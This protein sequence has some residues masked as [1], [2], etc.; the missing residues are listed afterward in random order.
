M[1]KFESC[2]PN[3]IV[4]LA[5]ILGIIIA[6]KLNPKEQN[7]VGNFFEALGQI[8]LTINAQVQNLQCENQNGN[9]NTKNNSSNTNEELQKQIDELKKYIKKLEN[10][11]DKT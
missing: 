3:E 2:T 5:T 1:K 9:N 6:E 8:I 4:I 7:V 11:I 10:K